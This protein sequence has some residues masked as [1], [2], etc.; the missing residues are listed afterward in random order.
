M[1]KLFKINIKDNNYLEILFYAFFVIYLF[2]NGIREVGDTG[3]YFSCYY[4]RPPL[5]PIFFNIVKYISPNNYSYIIL[6]I[7]ITFGLISIYHFNIQIKKFGKVSGIYS[8]FT[9]ILLS[10]PYFFGLRIANIMASE[11]LAYPLFL[12]SI[13]YLINALHNNT[14]K[15]FI[16]FFL[17]VSFIILTRGQYL[18]LYVL[19]LIVISI[20]ILRRSLKLRHIV[21]ILS[22]L[23]ISLIFNNLFERSYN[24]VLHLKFEKSNSDWWLITPA[25]YISSSADT[26]LFSYNK[27]QLELFKKMHQTL[28]KKQLSVEVFS[29]NKPGMNLAKYYGNNCNQIFYSVIDSVLITKFHYR[30]PE[31]LQFDYNKLPEVKKVVNMMSYKLIMHNFKKYA[32]FWTKYFIQWIGGYPYFVF[33]MIVFFIVFIEVLKNGFI[34]YDLTL[35][36]IIQLCSL[37]NCSLLALFANFETRYTSFEN[38]VFFVA[39][40]LVIYNYFVSSSV[41]RTNK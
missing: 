24:K 28:T 20:L 12:I 39:F 7:Q 1:N 3:A 15:D 26:L 30:I 22:F 13:S 35:L 16:L 27:T 36:F 2:L 29:Q 23:A 10:I 38:T 19:F 11:G 18:Y 9:L 4:N 8:L 32:L 17:T 31:T 33:F 34:R 14:V 6:F 21:I 37:L 5:I 40:F 41:S 25:L